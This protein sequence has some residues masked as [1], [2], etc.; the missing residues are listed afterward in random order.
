MNAE[1][2]EWDKL[3]NAAAEANRHNRLLNRLG[4]K[5]LKNLT[6]GSFESVMMRNLGVGVGAAY[7]FDGVAK[8]VSPKRQMVVS[9]EGT[10]TTETSSRSKALLEVAAGVGI[11][12]ASAFLKIG[13]AHSI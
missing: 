6:T 13:K 1:R 10:L 5:A 2:Q 11:A 7:T 12:T 4:R 9:E 3:V 8:L